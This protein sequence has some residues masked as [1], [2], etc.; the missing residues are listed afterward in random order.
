MDS[1]TINVR[2]AQDEDLPAI[3][4]IYAY[5]VLHGC[6]SF[7]EAPPSLD[8]IAR[9]R[10]NVRAKGL[11]FLVVEDDGRVIGFSYASPYHA[12]SAY[13]FTAQSSTYVHAD[14]HRRGFGRRVLS[15]VVTICEERG[16]KQIMA[17]VGDSRND[18]AIGLYTSV[19][20]RTVGHALRV[21]VKF[22]HW[23]DVV[24]MQLALGNQSIVTPESDPV[25]YV[26]AADQ[27]GP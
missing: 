5:H 3:A 15:A 17:A 16:Y 11:P 18:A 19:G 13:R 1:G 6:G 21:G 4:G 10:S 20:F 12:R 23:V 8:E 14:C 25:G 27:T 7:E 26:R 22:G 9:R 24:Y 2:V